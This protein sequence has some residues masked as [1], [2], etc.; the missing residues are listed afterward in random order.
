MGEQGRV[1][2]ER[3]RTRGKQG[4]KEERGMGGL[5]RS[6]FISK[7][8]GQKV[9]KPTRVFHSHPLTYKIV[10]AGSLTSRAHLYV[11]A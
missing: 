9:A 5:C 10:R 6:L 1:M 2:E 11:V 4:R 7:P 8:V 3:E